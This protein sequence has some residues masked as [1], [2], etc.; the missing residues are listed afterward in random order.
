MERLA[1][2]RAGSQGGT[3]NVISAGYVAGTDFFCGRL[4]DERHRT[5][6]EETHNKLPGTVDDIT[7]TACFLA[8]ARVGGAAWE[9]PPESYRI[10][11]SYQRASAARNERRRRELP[12]TKTDEKAIAAPAIIG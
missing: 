9:A 11:G 4:S 1:F 12:T 7:E 6:V 2:R 3:C 8:S 10:A 5:L